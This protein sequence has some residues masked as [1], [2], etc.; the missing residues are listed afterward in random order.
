M[1]R[2]A[3]TL[4]PLRR[5][6]LPWLIPTASIG[7][8]RV[9]HPELGPWHNESQ[10][11][12]RLDRFLSTG[13]HRR[14]DDD[15]RGADCGHHTTGGRPGG[16]QHCL[17]HLPPPL[18]RTPGAPLTTAHLIAGRAP[19]HGHQAPQAPGLTSLHHL[20]SRGG[21]HR[22]PVLPVL[23]PHRAAATDLMVR[24]INMACRVP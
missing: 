11:S 17:S 20:V 2:S 13:G 10:H 14:S 9:G 21:R 6:P 1:A 12:I 24:N 4:T 5:W 3:R 7:G 23:P 19:R 15:R 22:T 16:I 8:S 18:F